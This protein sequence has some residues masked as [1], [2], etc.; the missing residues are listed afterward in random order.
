MKKKTFSIEW[1]AIRL[2][3]IMLIIVG[4][5]SLTAIYGSQYYLQQTQARQ[6]KAS[7]AL[8]RVSNLHEETRKA[9]DII[10]S[11]Y[12]RFETLYQRNFIGDE[13]KLLWVNQL[14]QLES[15]VSLPYLQYDIGKDEKR[16]TIDE[17]IFTLDDDFHVYESHMTLKIGLVHEGDLFRLFATLK[18]Q[19]PAG[20]FSVESCDLDRQIEKDYSARRANIN[21]ICQLKWYTARITE[22]RRKR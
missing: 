11:S 3:L 21:A 8:E 14:H 19:K 16:L 1:R 13:Q 15:L 6:K 17:D 7:E 4:V 10:N 5:L 18:E 9:V 12:A 2:P 20:F 22:G